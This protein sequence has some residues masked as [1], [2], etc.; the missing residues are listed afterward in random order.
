MISLQTAVVGKVQIML[1]VLLAS[2]LLVLLVGCADLGGLL[3]TRAAAR[4]GELKVRA[5]LGAGRGRLVRQLVT[6]SLVIA[7]IGG[8][9]GLAL[10]YWL[11]RLIAVTATARLPR[12]H[13]ITLDT[14]I[15]LVSLALSVIAALACGLAPA[16]WITDGKGLAIAT[17]Q[18]SGD[19]GERRLLQT[20]VIVQ[21]TLALILA[22]GAGLLAR[23]LNGLLAVDAGF[24]P[25]HAVSATVSLPLASYPKANDIRGFFQRALQALDEL[26]GAHAVALSGSLP[27]GFFDQRGFTAEHTP[28]GVQTPAV[29]LS[30]IA[31][32]YFAALGV[33][34]KDG[35]LFTRS[36]DG[37]APRVVIVN[38]TLARTMWPGRPAV[39]ERVKWGIRESQS[40]WMTV[41]G[42]VGDVK[43]RGLDTPAQ[44]ESTFRTGRRRRRRS[45]IRA[46]TAIAAWR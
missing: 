21:V 3:L 15:V 19:K 24:R 18:S 38:E 32:S 12:A 40:P 6:E 37:E 36:D 39:G 46:S 8:A 30:S 11:T 33:P 28:S 44:A 16:L 10:A 7:S 22:I 25:E 45:S 27:L 5:A 13:E 41:V 14:T 20:L 34:L 29:A 42:V 35:R 43:Q 9:V 17:R 4:A 1:W 26:P 2:V 23:S 31:G